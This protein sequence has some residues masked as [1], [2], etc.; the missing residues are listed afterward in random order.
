MQAQSKHLALLACHNT[1]KLAAHHT[2][3]TRATAVGHPGH[4]RTVHQANRISP[5][6]LMVPQVPTDRFDHRHQLVEHSNLFRHAFP[7]GVGSAKNLALRLLEAW[8]NVPAHFAELLCWAGRFQIR[9]D[10][11]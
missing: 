9:F 3:A 11:S 6:Q 10:T 7:T 1:Q 4:G 5:I 8:R 2:L